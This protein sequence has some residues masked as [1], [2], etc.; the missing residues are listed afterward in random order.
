[1]F[2]ALLQF[3]SIESRKES[4]VILSATK[5]LLIN[6]EFDRKEVK[7]QSAVAM[8]AVFSQFS[9]SISHN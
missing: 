5:W 3:K 6:A 4:F 7:V 8:F 1:V 2:S 9:E